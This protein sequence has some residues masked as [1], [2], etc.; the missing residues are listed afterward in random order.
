MPV[1]PTWVCPLCRAHTVLMLP[2]S[3]LTAHLAWY[4]N[5]GLDGCAL[6]ADGVRHDSRWQATVDE[7]ERLLPSVEILYEGAA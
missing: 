7:M 6:D 5:I 2:L 4:H 1:V 3:E